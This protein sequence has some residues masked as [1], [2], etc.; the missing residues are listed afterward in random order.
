MVAKGVW[1]EAGQFQRSMNE[2]TVMDV[3]LPQLRNQEGLLQHIMMDLYNRGFSQDSQAS[4][5]NA[6]GSGT[7]NL[8]ID[9]LR[10]VSTDEEL[11]NG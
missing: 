7:T 2:S 4:S 1:R 9:F 10:F 3:L 8:G 11:Q 5:I 6:I